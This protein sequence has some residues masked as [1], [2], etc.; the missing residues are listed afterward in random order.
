MDR[1][2][3]DPPTLTSVVGTLTKNERPAY[4]KALRGTV[5]EAFVLTDIGSNSLG[6]T[7]PLPEPSAL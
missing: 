6:G 1:V 2:K 7:K 3:V 4:L 5:V